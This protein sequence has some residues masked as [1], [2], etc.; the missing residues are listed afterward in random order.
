MV[1]DLR[2]QAGAHIAA[3]AALGFAESNDL[4]PTGIFRGAIGGGGSVAIADAPTS[5]LVAT[6][7]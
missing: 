5:D 6:L 2:S 7:G 1:A 3:P 4:S